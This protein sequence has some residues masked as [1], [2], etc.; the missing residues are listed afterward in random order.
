MRLA[1]PPPSAAWTHRGARAGFEIAFF[2]NG[3]GG[4]LVTG[5]TTADE[6]GAL[7]SVGY[8]IEVDGAW[9]TR[10]V[11]ATA[12]IDGADRT[13]ELQ[14]NADGRWTVDGRHRPELDGCV[15]VDFESSAV[16]NTLPIHRID[17]VP[18]RAVEVPAAFV[19]ADLTVQRLEQSYVPIDTAV[20]P[21]FRYYSATFHFAC[22]LRYDAAGLVLDYPGI[23]VR[24]S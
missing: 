23:A 22:E 12:L 9:V 21:R 3:S 19:R 16:T 14:R 2:R 1:P 5:R 24:Y 7:W 20:G 8:A 13:V 17:F 18:G 15:D 10:T 4:T 11:R 6:A